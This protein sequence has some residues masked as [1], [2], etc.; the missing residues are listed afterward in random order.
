MIG[1]YDGGKS[2]LCGVLRICRNI[3]ILKMEITTSVVVHIAELSKLKLTEEEIKKFTTELS[4][5]V[6]YVNAIQKFN[7]S[8]TLSNKP[9]MC[10]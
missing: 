7:V 10:Y 3:N 1:F 6:N 2:L 9:E 8:N 4:S 5:I